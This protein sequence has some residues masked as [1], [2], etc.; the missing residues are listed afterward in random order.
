MSEELKPDP[1]VFKK[2]ITATIPFA[3]PADRR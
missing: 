3:K 2:L 1:E